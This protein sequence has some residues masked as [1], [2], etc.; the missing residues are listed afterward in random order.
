MKRI[1]LLVAVCLLATAA[2]GCGKGS[3]AESRKADLETE[4]LPLLDD[5]IRAMSELRGYR[6]KGS[7]EMSAGSGDASGSGTLRMEIRSEVENTDGRANQYI[8][9]EMGGLATEAYIY[10]DYFYQ[11]VPGQGWTKSSLAQ[12]QVQNLSTGVISEEQM[13]L[14]AETVEEAIVRD[15]GEDGKE[16]V[17]LL[18]KEFL[19]RSLERFREEAGEAAK[20]QME[21]WMSAMEEAAEGFSATLRLLVGKGDHL[22]REMEMT[23]EMKDVPQLGTYRSTMHMEAYDYDA[24]I[25]IELPP[26]AEKAALSGAGSVR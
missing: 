16:M 11:E 12:Y 13:R 21:Q 10:G 25:H 22:I 17:L 15:K 18:G 1:Y 26:E 2:W 23:I 4:V 7:M 9:M 14:I 19:L 24:Q 6:M 3:S 20:G 5:S 8:H